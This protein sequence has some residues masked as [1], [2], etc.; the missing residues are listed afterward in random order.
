MKK[1]TLSA[2]Q[3]ED[4]LPFSF[5]KAVITSKKTEDHW[6]KIAGKLILEDQSEDEKTDETAKF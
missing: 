1:K 5:K 2:K 4:E 6:Q 3:R